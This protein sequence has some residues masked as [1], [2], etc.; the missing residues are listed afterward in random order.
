MT[1]HTTSISISILRFHC[2]SSILCIRIISKCFNYRIIYYSTNHQDFSKIPLLENPFHL[3]C[4][5]FQKFKIALHR[6]YCLSDADLIISTLF[7]NFIIFIQHF[8]ILIHSLL[9]QTNITTSHD[10]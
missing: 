7:V 8:P 10:G 1:P 2:T 3:Q 4:I 5:D 9:L 6:C